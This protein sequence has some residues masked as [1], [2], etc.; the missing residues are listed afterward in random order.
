M[1][2]RQMDV[3][4]GPIG[5]Y[6]YL[7]QRARVAP[8]MLRRN[9]SYRREAY[10]AERRRVNAQHSSAPSGK[11]ES[12]AHPDDGKERADARAA[13]GGE[14]AGDM[15]DA[16]GAKR[17][18]PDDT[19]HG[20]ADGGGGVGGKRAQDSEQPCS[21][22]S[23]H[24]VKKTAVIFR[25]RYQEGQQESVHRAPELRCPWCEMTCGELESLMWHLQGKSEGVGLDAGLAYPSYRFT[26]CTSHSEFARL[27]RVRFYQLSWRLS[28]VFAR[29][30]SLAR[31]VLV[32]A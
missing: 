14:A 30:A 6:A 8:I 20:G 26:V 32:H 15:L 17:D 24:A 28:D 5:L 12:D 3:Y 25:M 29:T 4:T 19:A 1:Q 7:A 9:L 31:P 11:L 23:M 21:R 18:A 16:S 27:P 13:R 10:E 22:R 2:S